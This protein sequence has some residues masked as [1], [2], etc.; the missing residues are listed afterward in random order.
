MKTLQFTPHVQC[1]E[2]KE[3]GKRVYYLLAIE[4]CINRA[5]ELVDC[6]HEHT[7]ELDAD[8]YGQSALCPDNVPIIY[9]DNFP[10]SRNEQKEL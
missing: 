1:Y 2:A 4:I 3:E 8:R 5:F 10:K 6:K 9:T 7:P